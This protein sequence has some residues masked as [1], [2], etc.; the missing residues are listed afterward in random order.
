MHCSQCREG[1]GGCSYCEHRKVSSLC[2]QGCGGGSY[3]E[4]GKV[5]SQ[6]KQGCCGKQPLADVLATAGAVAK[7]AAGAVAKESM[8]KKGKTDTGKAP[9]MDVL[10][11]L[12]AEEGI[13]T[14]CT[15]R[16]RLR[17]RRGRL[18]G[19]GDTRL[20][21]SRSCS[22]AAVLEFIITPLGA[23]PITFLFLFSVLTPVCHAHAS[24]VW[25]H[26]QLDM[27]VSSCKCCH[28]REGVH[29]VCRGRVTRTCWSRGIK[30]Q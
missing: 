22:G 15:H 16:C 11:C 1:C 5:S 17:S 30:G 9:T 10:R 8:P 20:I 25:Q 13:N 28:T 26:L 23:C 24:R 27:G 3:C 14:L 18:G 6:C 2:T 12:S 21:I 7:E 4:H 29:C 19:G